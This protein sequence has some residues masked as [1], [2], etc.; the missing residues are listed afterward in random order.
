MKKRSLRLRADILHEFQYV[1]GTFGIALIEEPWLI[2]GF[3]PK[4]V[5]HFWQDFYIPNI[6]ISPSNFWYLS[7]HFSFQD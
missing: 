7:P 2:S 4:N 3:W 5:T 6:Y 1:F